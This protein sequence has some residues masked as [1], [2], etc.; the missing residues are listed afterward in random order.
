MAN[1]VTMAMPPKELKRADA[2][3]IVSRDGKRV[4]TLT[5]SNGSVVWFPPYTSYGLIMQWKKFDQVFREHA[6]R[7]EK[8]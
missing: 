3:F 4:G 1:K 2:E 5:V 6:T 7:E 8:R